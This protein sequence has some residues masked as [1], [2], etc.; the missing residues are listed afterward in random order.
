[1]A[2]RV[3]IDHM[4]PR[5]L[6]WLMSY[7]VLAV[8]ET[9]T[10]H[11]VWL[12]AY[13]GTASGTMAQDQ[14]RLEAIDLNAAFAPDK[15]AQQLATKRVVFVGEIHDRYD[16]H[17]NQLEVIQRLQG[18]DP[19]LAI[20]VE[21]FPRSSQP[22]I[23][24]YI[25]GK[26]NEQEFLRAAGYFENWGYDYRLYAPIFRYAR[27]Q[28][29]P[30]RALNVPN[31]LPAAVAKVGIKGLTEAQRANLPREMEP[32]GEA[33]R[34]RLRQAFQA[35][36]ATKPGDFEHFVEA[37]SVWDAG[38]AETAA[39]Y[40]DANPGRRLVILCGS[41]HVAF[42]DGV[43]QRLER[44]TSTPGPPSVSASRLLLVPALPT[45]F[46]PRRSRACHHPALQ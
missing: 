33:Y 34:K 40:L 45:H 19:N 29:I 9:R 26:I 44:R 46:C 4:Y 14:R 32:A 6:K 35:H 31:S 8:L 18:S 30:V 43:P 13:L 1:M 27:E 2:R 7:A 20:G 42:G 17:L 41:G 24:D 5:S 15:L 28:H 23:D 38:M 21:Y 25:A 36:G 39:A 22:H 37:Q 12:L 10:L 16:Q 3:N 11:V